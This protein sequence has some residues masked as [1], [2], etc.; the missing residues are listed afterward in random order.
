MERLFSSFPRKRE[1]SDP[2]KTLGS[3]SSLRSGR[4]DEENIG[5][6]GAPA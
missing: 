1:P 2:A 4:N 5:I 3:G 6:E